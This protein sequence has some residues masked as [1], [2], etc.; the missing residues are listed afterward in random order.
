ME[1]VVLKEWISEQGRKVFAEAK[2]FATEDEAN[3][4]C[5]FANMAMGRAAHFWVQ[6][7]PPEG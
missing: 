3:Q 2:R 1:F 4:Y 6:W 5:K 7:D